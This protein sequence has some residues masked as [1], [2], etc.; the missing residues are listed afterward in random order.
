MKRYDPDF[1]C[2]MT[3]CT[4]GE[5]VRLEDLTPAAPCFVVLAF[6]YGGHGNT[7]PIGVFPD[8]E[9]AEAAARAHR[10]FR[11]G[12]YDHRIYEFEVGKANDDVGHAVNSRPCIEAN[13]KGDSQSPAQN[14]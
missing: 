6:R 13:V 11:G 1:E 9:G 3:E 8:R 14:L 2:S 5:W 4:A 12:K 10:N 7:F